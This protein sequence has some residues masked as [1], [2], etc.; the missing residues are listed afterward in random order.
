MKL[1]KPRW[2]PQTAWKK[3]LH[4]DLYLRFIV[5]W[6]RSLC[7]NAFVLWLLSVVSFAT[8][9]PWEKTCVREPRCPPRRVQ[10]PLLW[11]G[12]LQG[13]LLAKTLLLNEQVSWATTSASTKT[14]HMPYAL[15]LTTTIYT[16]RQKKECY[17]SPPLDSKIWPLL[18]W[19]KKTYNTNAWCDLMWLDLMWF[20][21]SN[22]A[23]SGK[24]P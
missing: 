14:S 21:W 1:I 23:K 2:A 3:K 15:H 12:D 16:L 9:P 10:S 20:T 7:F 22:V 5:L 6:I 19:R 24:R 11:E 18:R 8:L 17:G 4:C 13:L